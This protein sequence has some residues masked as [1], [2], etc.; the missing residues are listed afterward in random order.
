M[1]YDRIK[2]IHFQKIWKSYSVQK[3]FAKNVLFGLYFSKL[4]KFFFYLTISS[5]V[6]LQTFKFLHHWKE[7]N[8]SGKMHTCGFEF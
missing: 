3:T 4:F 6:E 1:E 2:P 5:V 7:K 8:F